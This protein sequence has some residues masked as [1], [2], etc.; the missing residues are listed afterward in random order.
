[1]MFDQVLRVVEERDAIKRWQSGVSTRHCVSSSYTA[2][3]NKN[4]KE[5]DA[6]KRC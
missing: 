4:V 3:P 6:K 5:S 2:I 1:M